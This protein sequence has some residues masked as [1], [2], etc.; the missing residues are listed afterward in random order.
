MKAASV[1]PEPVGA[2]I[3]TL[4]PALIAGQA[5]RCATVGAGKLRSNQAG[6]AGWN[7]ADTLIDANAPRRNLGRASNCRRNP[8]LIWLARQIWGAI[9]PAATARSRGK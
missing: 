9:A 1:L 3:N 5:S 7:K 6:T 8:A 4:R 2:A